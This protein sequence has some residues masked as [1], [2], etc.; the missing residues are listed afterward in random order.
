[1]RYVRLRVLV[2]KHGI[3]S[4]IRIVP[5]G[6]HRAKTAP[7][8]SDTTPIAAPAPYSEAATATPTA[9]IAASPTATEPA[10]PTITAGITSVDDCVS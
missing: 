4:G 8:G 10:A 5:C 1:M 7:A 2:A 6:P 9:P 3:H